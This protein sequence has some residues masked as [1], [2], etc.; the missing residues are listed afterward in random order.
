M[1]LVTVLMPG[2]PITIALSKSILKDARIE[3]RVKG[4]TALQNLYA[5]GQVEIQV[6]EE[7]AEEARKLLAD[8]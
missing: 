6:Y 2:D 1:N 5:F 7:D 3:F 4:D 8:L